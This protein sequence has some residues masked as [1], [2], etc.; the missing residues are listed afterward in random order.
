MRAGSL[1]FYAGHAQGLSRSTLLDRTAGSVH[2]GYTLNELAPGG[3]VERCL[4]AYEKALYVLDGAL[5][6]ERDGYRVPLAK[7]DYALVATATPHAFH[8]A[9]GKP[10]HWVEIGAPQP[11]PADGWQDTFFLGPAD[12]AGAVEA[13]A[14]GDPRAKSLGRY[15]GTMP[16]GVDMHGDLRGFAIK[17]FLNAESGAV[18]MTMFTVEFA[19]G[20]L[21]NHHD[22]PFEEA[23][24]VLEGDVDIVFDGERYTLQTGDFAWTGVG[25]RHAFFPV[26]GR[27]VRWLEIQ[28]PQPPVQN[29]MRWHARWEALA[30]DIKSRAR[31]HAA[32]Q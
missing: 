16:P 25:P 6:L 1:G 30:R 23:Y 24:L 31:E 10:A 7:D 9:G 19:R 20:G 12:W 22:H 13:P 8:N 4:H 14:P 29:G 2:V 15:D 18:H 5:E 21:C 32:A 11:K 26:E 27:P 17:H 28:A 3:A